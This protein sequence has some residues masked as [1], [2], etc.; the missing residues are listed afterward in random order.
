MQANATAPR[1]MTPERIRGMLDRR[2]I[3]LSDREWQ[4]VLTDPI[5]IG[6]PLLTAPDANPKIAKGLK[7][8]VA[9]AGLM[10]MPADGSGLN[11][12]PRATAGC[13]AACLNTAGRGGLGLDVDGLNDSQRARR[14]RTLQ[15]F[16][17]RSEF[18][19]RLVRETELHEAKCLRKGFIAA[20]RLNVLS[21]VPW[22]RIPVARGGRAYP[23]IMRA[24]PR[25]R[26]Y[27]YTKRTDRGP[28]PRNYH[29]TFSLAEDNDVD[30]S[31]MLERG[32]NVAVVL[33]S[34]EIARRAGTRYARMAPLPACW[35]GRRVIDGDETDLRFKDPR[36][37]YVGLRA[38]G[39]AVRDGSGFVREVPV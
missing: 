7:R 36:G 32:I 24:F 10:L 12:C 18:M 5:G 30:A 23:N 29:L 34:P 22:E 6:R 38:K 33:R 16:A 35:N 19:S 13:K 21:D 9:T 26:F 27:D 11:V 28:L 31:A 15:F 37:V 39:R 8:G 25:V 4:A 14:R 1:A 17:R 2:G 20:E 3:V